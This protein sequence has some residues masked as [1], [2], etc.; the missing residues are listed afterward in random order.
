MAEV[1]VRRLDDRVVEHHRRNASK[2]GRSLEEELR[3]V[4]TDA[5]LAKRRAWAERLRALRKEMHER[6]G[7]LPDSTPLIR[8]ERDEA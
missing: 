5:A 3:R 6:Y 8:A 2:A 4:L 7:Q 1:K